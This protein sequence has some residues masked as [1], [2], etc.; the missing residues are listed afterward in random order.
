MKRLGTMLHTM[1]RL[2]VRGSGNFGIAIDTHGAVLGPDCVLVRRTAQ[3]CRCVAPDEAAVLQNF[4]FGDDPEPGWLWGQCRRIADALDNH[5]IALA[6]ILGLAI[7][8]DRLDSEK[9]QRLTAAA[10]F[11]KV[12]FNPSE[13][14]IPAGRSGGGDW[15][16][17]D[18]GGSS[19]SLIPVQITIPWDLPVG[20]PGEIPGMPT[21]ITPLP[22]DFPGAERKRLPFP[23]NPFPRD[24]DC[25]DEWNDAYDYCDEQEK[26]GKFKPGYSG[27]GKDYRS[28][29]LGRVS[30]RCG[31][32]LV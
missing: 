16:T 10:P 2:Y 28:C 31:G 15:T 26:N 20:I 19:G 27:P 7:P 22:F 8:I 21:E 1:R 3:G 24:P 29:V 6:Q 25:A 13:P 23:T 17:G 9:L 32:N 4:L 30:Q 14:R 11:L 18:G 5:E 12:D